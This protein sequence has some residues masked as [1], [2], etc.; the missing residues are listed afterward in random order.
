MPFILTKVLDDCPVGELA[1]LHDL[2]V[3]TFWLLNAGVDVTGMFPEE[4]LSDSALEDKTEPPPPD[5]PAS[6]NEPASLAPAPAVSAIK[7]QQGQPKAVGGQNA[8]ELDDTAFG[9]PTPNKRRRQQPKQPAAPAKP[10]I[11]QQSEPCPTLTTFFRGLEFESEQYCS[12]MR[13]PKGTVVRVV[14]SHAMDRV[15]DFMSKTGINLDN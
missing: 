4:E 3:S 5:E 10:T 8:V 7:Q 11:P 1:K 2:K 13:V 9:Q 12:T 6:T 14:A 15:S